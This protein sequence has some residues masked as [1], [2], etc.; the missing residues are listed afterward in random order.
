MCTALKKAGLVEYSA[1]IFGTV[2]A[3]AAFFVMINVRFYGDDYYYLTF[4]KM[5]SSEFWGT[6]WWHYMEANGRAIVHI[7]DTFFLAMPSIVWQILNSVFL[8]L[9]VFCGA[10]IILPQ[11]NKN[12]SGEDMRDSGGTS[13]VKNIV[14]GVLLTAAVFC[15]DIYTTRQS[16]YW[17]TGSFNYVYP[18][19]MFMLFWLLLSKMDRVSKAD[20]GILSM[21]LV[22]VLGFISAA[23]TEQ[24][25]MMTIGLSVLYVIY[26]RIFEKTLDKRMIVVTA[27]AVIG[28]L[29][30]FLAPATFLRYQLENQEQTNTITIV[31]QNLKILYADFIAA[32]GMLYYMCIF[33]L[34]P[35]VYLFKKGS[36]IAAYIS[37]VIAVLMYLEAADASRVFTVIRLIRAAVIALFIAVVVI[38]A[39]KK[40]LA[41]RQKLPAFALILCVGSQLMML[42]SPVYGERNMLCAVLLLSLYS[43]TTLAPCLRAGKMRISARVVLVTLIAAVVLFSSF[44][45]YTTIDGYSANR[46]VDERNMQLISTH[47]PGEPLQQYKLIDDAYGWSMPYYS[48]YHLYY[49]K[50]NYDIEDDIDIEWLMMR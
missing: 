31:L 4:A 29:T 6:H 18:F 49:Y 30:V 26:K 3:I 24:N 40:Q 48:K 35:V 1:Y 42:V 21:L 33:M 37:P 38:T 12:V 9:F 34:A 16:V 44:K 28:G 50:I 11:G 27:I 17:I 7:L 10:R 45:M 20:F 47:K 32:P 25:A 43:A 8:G 22:S 41:D 23:S 39:L 2:A 5:S 36:K 19:V 14:V 46:A 13:V 15:L